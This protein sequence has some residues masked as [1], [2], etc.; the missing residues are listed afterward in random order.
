MKGFFK[1]I[2]WQNLLIVALTMVMM[3]YFIIMPLL[4]KVPVTMAG[5]QGGTAFLESCLPLTD[6]IILVLS[7]VLITAGGYVI[8]DYFDIR[9]D[10]INRGEVIV[11]TKIPRRLAMMLHS[12][13]NILGVAGGFYVS[14][15]A[16]YFLLGVL[17]LFVSG[18]LYFYSASYKRQFLIGN[19]IV[20][21]LTAMV[22]LM[23]I[24]YEWPALFRFY[25]ETVA[26]MPRLGFLFYWVGGF[27]LFA[28]LTTLAREII[29]DIEDF[30]GDLAYGRNTMPVII[31]V[32]GS[33]IVAVSL[34][35]ITAAL[36]YLAWFFFVHDNITL[37]YI[38]AVITLPLL[39][40]IFQVTVSKTRRQMHAAS[41]LMKIIMLA[42]ILYSVIV[43]V[44]LTWN[45]V[46]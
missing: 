13:F 3:R 20:A 17:F 31:G 30:E 46:G 16:G 36:L 9:T 2:R 41:N 28:F 6:F 33:K 19:L 11:G 44:I 18:L 1:L 7:T 23:V 37:I 10:L 38:S 4:S 8:N 15:R 42:G 25:S 34:I 40:V 45:L 26:E 35:I 22:P 24:V 14:A 27:A 29:K 12:V 5:V 39:Y 43:K 21:L 32:T